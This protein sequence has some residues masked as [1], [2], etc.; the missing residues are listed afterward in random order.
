MTA[1][2]PERTFGTTRNYGCDHPYGV[3]RTPRAYGASRSYAILAGDH[4]VIVEPTR[5][6]DPASHLAMEP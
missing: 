5:A 6:P 2:L 1:Y 3:P 4:D